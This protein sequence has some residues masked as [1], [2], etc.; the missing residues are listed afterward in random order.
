LQRS[1]DYARQSDGAEGIRVG[2]SLYALAEVE[3]RM[4]QF[5]AAEANAKRSIELL[6]ARTS[7]DSVEVLAATGFLTE[8]Y[9]QQGRYAEGEALL[10]KMLT[11]RLRTLSADSTWAITARNNLAQAIQLQGRI[12]ES[13]ALLRENVDLLRAAEQRDTATYFISLNNLASLLEQAGDYAASIEMFGEVLDRAQAHENDPRLPTYR[14]NLGRSLLLAGRLDAAWPLLNRDIEGG[15]DSLD[16][17]IERGR[18]LAHLADWMRRSGRFDEAMR[19]ADQASAQF[20]ALFPAE[21]PRHGAVARIRALVLR[22]QG[23]LAEAEPELRRAVQIL[24]A[25]IG[26]DANATLEAELQLAQLLAARGEQA[27]ANTLLTR[28]APL[29]GVR[30]VDSAPARRQ[31]AELQQKLGAG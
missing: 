11:T 13:T 18:R 25:G 19:Y 31:F 28:M 29:L 17:N 8:V 30:F 2:Q 20:T 1:L 22:D 26:K 27:E 21:H 12:V 7:D 5:D 10:R 14:Q 9:E 6:R 15:T 3:M 4:G 16:L 24:G 23:R